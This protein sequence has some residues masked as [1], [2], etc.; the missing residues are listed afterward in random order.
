[1]LRFRIYYPT[2]QIGNTIVTSRSLISQFGWFDNNNNNNWKFTF[3]LV[4]IYWF[5]IE[6]CYPGRAATEEKKLMSLKIRSI[7]SFKFQVIKYT[8]F[9]WS[10]FYLYQKKITHICF[11]IER[12][13]NQSVLLIQVFSS[14]PMIH[15]R[16]GLRIITFKPN[17]TIEVF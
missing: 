14:I 10:S 17:K 1:M 4:V 8:K 13:Q 12:A 6:H 16:S 15:F 9:I 2:W 3:L 11:V 7:R 5:G